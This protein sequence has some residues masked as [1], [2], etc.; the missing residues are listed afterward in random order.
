MN[1]NRSDI[2]ELFIEL[3]Q[4][5]V[6]NR[7]EL[8]RVPTAKE[9]ADLYDESER[10]AVT[11]IMVAGLERLPKEQRPRQELLLQWIGISEQIRQRNIS[12]N[13]RRK[14]LQRKLK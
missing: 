11:G 5:G 10:Q 9:W 13:S 8:S 7:G 14:Q 4:V 6:G 3:L 1:T 2:H 12:L